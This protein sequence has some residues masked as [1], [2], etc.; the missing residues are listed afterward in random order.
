LTSEQYN[1]LSPSSRVGISCLD[2][3]TVVLKDETDVYGT[4]TPKR[5]T[6]ASS[7]VCD[8]DTI[9]IAKKS[10]DGKS[11]K[12]FFV[13]RHS[14]MRLVCAS[15]HTKEETIKLVHMKYKGSGLNTLF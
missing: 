15:P 6:K 4:F 1:K 12:I 14:D 8:G 10:P 2:V 13:Y 9:Y 5:L 3:D 11:S 7:F